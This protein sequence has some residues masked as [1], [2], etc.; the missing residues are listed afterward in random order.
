MRFHIIGVALRVFLCVCAGKGIFAL[1]TAGGCVSVK[2]TRP[3]AVNPTKAREAWFSYTWEH[4][5]GLPGLFLPKESDDARTRLLVPFFAEETI[6][7][8]EE[9]T[10]VEESDEE[11]VRYTLTKLGPIWASEI[12]PDS[13]MGVVCFAPN[14]DGEGCTMTWSCTFT[15]LKRRWLWQAVTQQM[16][17]SAC[18]NLASYVATPQMYTHITRL[19]GCT[20]KRAMEEWATFVF[21]EGGGLPINP[22]FVV[23]SAKDKT[24][25][26]VEIL[27][28]PPFLREK[29]VSVDDNDT[30]ACTLGYKVLNP[31]LFTYQVHT[32]AGRVRFV[33]RDEDVV[34]MVWEVEIRPIN[35]FGPLTKALTEVIVTTLA[36]NLKS[37]LSDPNA[38]VPLY[39][40]R[41][42]GSEPLAQIRID[43]WLGG[44]LAA[45]LSDNRSTLEQTIALFQP[46]TWG[47]STY[48]NGESAE[49]SLSRER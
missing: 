30:N 5:G 1:S 41:G 11:I 8:D 39:L 35:G 12:Q 47:R 44:V 37:H 6:L 14:R 23:T 21:Q 28:I 17:G 48:E 2:V 9:I 19:V 22:P 4:A 15:T 20:P 42:A 33:Q 46:W 26:N 36:R 49:W 18:D 40:P 25:Q 16:I 38:A 31:G 34:V 7:Q 10:T 24:E 27:R 45:H 3:L 13:H 43:S 29:I 32:H